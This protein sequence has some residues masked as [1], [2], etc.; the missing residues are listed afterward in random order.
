MPDQ[1]EGLRQLVRRLNVQG[2][3]PRP[4]EP[5]PGR[6]ARTVAVTGGKGG[7]GKSSLAAN[8]GLALAAAGRRT[9]LVDADLGLASA[10]LLLGVRPR[11]TLAEVALD[12][13]EVREA[14]VPVAPR[15]DLL[16]GASGVADLADL[17]PVARQTLIASLAGLDG[18]YD[19]LLVDTAAGAGEQVRA[20]LRAADRVLAVTTPDP[21][22]VTDAYAL[23]KLLAA[24]GHRGLGLTVNMARSEDEGARVAGRIAQVARRYLGAEIELL[25]SVPF[26]WQ[27]AAA[28]RARR[29]LLTAAP[30]APA[31]HAV[32]RIGERLKSWALPAV[33]E[34]ERGGLM[35]WLAGCCNA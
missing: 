4:D 24:E 29:P 16:P 25:G 30:F 3:R 1:A 20:F 2:P 34:G 6:R 8:L 12:G 35:A 5:A 27:A 19:V 13:L 10:D 7:V 31:S 9:L 21:A 17:T 14:L 15:L 32:R 26:D 28:V 33:R 11:A 22:A 23:F 18:E